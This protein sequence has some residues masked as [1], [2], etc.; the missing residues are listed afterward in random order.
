[1]RFEIGGEHVDGLSLLIAMFEFVSIHHR[2][3]RLLSSFMAGLSA[4]AIAS[5]TLNI[6]RD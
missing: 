1:M 4:G 2:L 3:G 5:S 6:G